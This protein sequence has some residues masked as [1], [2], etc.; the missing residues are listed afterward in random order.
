MIKCPV[1]HLLSHVRYPVFCPALSVT[2]FHA[3]G[4]KA[5]YFP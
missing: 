3:T 4:L 1:S 5:L 2:Q